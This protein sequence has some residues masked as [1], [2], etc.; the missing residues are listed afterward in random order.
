MFYIKI[1]RTLPDLHIPFSYRIMKFFNVSKIIPDIHDNAKINVQVTDSTVDNI[2]PSLADF[3][4]HPDLPSKH[5][6]SA[7]LFERQFAA[8]GARKRKGTSHI[9]HN[10]PRYGRIFIENRYRH[11][12]RPFARLFVRLTCIPRPPCIVWDCAVSDNAVFQFLS[13]MGRHVRSRERRN[14]RNDYYP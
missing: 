4:S 1:K 11:S 7:V 3:L 12:L 5:T 2:R 13:D 14:P 10:G 6:K 9:S 8:R